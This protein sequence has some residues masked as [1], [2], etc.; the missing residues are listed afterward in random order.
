M[1]RNVEPFDSGLRESLSRSQTP[2]LT[3]SVP[4]TKTLHDESWDP[5]RGREPGEVF[6]KQKQPCLLLL[7]PPGH[8]LDSR[9][10]REGR[11]NQPHH[12][13]LEVV[14]EG[15]GLL[16]NPLEDQNW[17]LPRPNPSPQ[18]PD[19]GTCHTPLPPVSGL[20]LSRGD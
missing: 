18:P 15:S 1:G 5:R 16:G 20:F 3:T 13:L 12:P 4:G 9:R 10:S 19:T 8:P 2:S 7:F 11:L 14:G 6:T 17:V